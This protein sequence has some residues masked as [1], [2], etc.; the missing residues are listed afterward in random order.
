MGEWKGTLGNKWQHN[1]E[2]ALQHQEKGKIVITYG[3]G[4]TEDYLEKGNGTIESISNPG[5]M[6]TREEGGWLLY[7]SDGSRYRFDRSGRL[8]L[9]ERKS[10]S[11]IIL[12][13]D[14]DK[15][16]KISNRS[17]YIELKYEG[18]YLVKISDMVGRSAEYRYD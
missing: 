6:L 12:T 2:I 1:Y 8:T 15:L 7:L 10:G 3:D 4:K 5:N 13:H 14:R 18:R 11:R 16:V 9:I 17:G